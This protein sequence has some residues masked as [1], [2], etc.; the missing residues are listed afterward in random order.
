MFGLC[1]DYYDKY[2]HESFKKMEKWENVLWLF[3]LVAVITSQR[4]Y[5]WGLMH[6]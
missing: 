6:T 3:P 1:V 4:A 5:K 2:G